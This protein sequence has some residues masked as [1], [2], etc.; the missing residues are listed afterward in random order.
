MLALNKEGLKDTA[1]W[2]EK[3]YALPTFDREAVSKRTKENPTWIHFGAGNIFR[4]F[5]A[6]V[7]QT[8]LN[9]GVLDTGLIVAEGYDYEILES[10]NRPH[11]EFSILVTLKADG[12]NQDIFGQIYFDIQIPE[13]DYKTT[14]QAQIS[15]FNDEHFAIGH[16]RLNSTNPIVINATYDGVKMLSITYENSDTYDHN[17]EENEDNYILGEKALIYDNIYKYDTI[18]KLRSD[19]ERF[20][21]NENIQIIGSIL[22][23]RR[24]IDSEIVYDKYFDSNANI[25][26]FV[27]NQEINNILFSNNEYVINFAVTQP[28]EYTIRAFIPETNKTE[29]SVDVMTI[30]VENNGENNE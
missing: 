24:E 11:D 7:C 6:N 16:A 18:V 28:G 29:E 15:T 27:E 8:L 25:K 9:Q 21:V 20:V 22:Y 3:G 14:A 17:Y 12:T 5:Q 10:Y 1:A 26:F 19:Q 2:Q 30:T 4:A 23:N 13:E